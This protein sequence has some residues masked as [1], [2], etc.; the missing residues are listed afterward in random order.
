MLGS[1]GGSS[2]LPP[3]TEMLPPI[4]GKLAAPMDVQMFEPHTAASADKGAL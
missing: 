2:A 1:A 3:T 4:K